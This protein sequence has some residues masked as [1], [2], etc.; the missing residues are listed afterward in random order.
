MISATLNVSPDL[1]RRTISIKGMSTPLWYEIIP[2][3]DH[4]LPKIFNYDFVA[5]ALLP[6]AMSLQQNLRIYGPVSRLLLDNL[7]IY[8][9]IWEN[10]LPVKFKKIDIIPNYEI[11]DT[12]IHQRN[13]ATC[14]ASGG[15]DSS[16]M[17][18]R[19]FNNM[20]GRLN[21][22]IKQA[23]LVHGFDM[24]I[25]HID[26]F[27]T[28]HYSVNEICNSINTPL[29]TVRTNWMKNFSRDWEMMFILG[30]SAILHQFNS[31]SSF[32][33]FAQ[34][35][36]YNN[37]TIPWSNN[38]MSNAFLSGGR[39]KIQPCGGSYTRSQKITYLSQF[40]K[41]VNNL[42]V[43]WEGMRDGTNCG[44]CEKC[45]RTQLD[46]HLAKT[47]LPW[48]FKVP[49]TPA[50]VATIVAK[51]SAQLSF[52]INILNEFDKKNNPDDA[53]LCVALHECIAASQKY[54]NKIL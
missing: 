8:Q 16:F 50:R 11:I 24:P 19:H 30:I 37:E 47:P 22:D 2:P 20:E 23:I 34:D 51:N 48:P 15:V 41:I 54:Q 40:P 39:L 1:S 45:I 31:K 35:N 49:L 17:L 26:G 13:N 10:W 44:V 6:L 42:R 21:R 38:S 25:D 53:P 12:Q 14:M 4:T 52:L 7:E 5:L 9:S 32:G 18:L 33:I 36:P 28:L 29:Y 27:N 43:C 3:P 46:F